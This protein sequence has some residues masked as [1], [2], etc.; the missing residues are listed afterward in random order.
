MKRLAIPFLAGLLFAAGLAVGGMTDPQKVLGFLDV[1]GDWDP[2]LAFVMGGALAVYYPVQR[3]ILKRP[4][5]LIAGS[6]RIPKGTRID[7]SLIG[8]AVLFGIGW[9]IA[10][11]CPGPALVSAV[12]SWDAAIFV[13]AMIGGMLLHRVASTRRPLVGVQS[14]EEKTTFPTLASSSL[15]ASRSASTA[16]ASS[17]RSL[18]R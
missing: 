17:S 6:F 5:P 2:S 18:K 16:L 1:T 9:G 11:Y 15:A 8:G 13:A 3:I 7:G 12:V 14:S 10:G 4:R